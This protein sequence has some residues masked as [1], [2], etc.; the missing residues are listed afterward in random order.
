MWF[1]NLQIYRFTKPF[2]L[3]DSALEEKLAAHTFTPCNNQQTQSLGWVSPLGKNS[4]QLVHAANGYM[5]VCVREQEKLLPAS[6]INEQLEE[7]VRDIEAKEGREVYRK[8]KV[9]LKEALIFDLLPRAFSRSRLHFAYI[10]P[11]H[12]YLV[13]N[14]AS[15]SKAENLLN[16]LRES[17]GSLAVIP[18]TCKSLVAQ[19]MT[20]WLNSGEIPAPFTLGNDCVLKDLQEGASIRCKQYDLQADEIIAHITS[21]M[22]VNQLQVNWKDR[23]SCVIDDKLAIKQLK[24]TDLV[25]EDSDAQYSDD[26]AGQFDADFAIMTAELHAFIGDLITAFGGQAD[27]E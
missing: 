21:G 24:F 1:N 2:T 17:I 23:I 25:Q 14:S 15:A 18:L 4:Q 7:K 20:H 9:D 10:A 8:E 26:P 3:N 11:Q 22:V 16:L 13:V 12:G 5:M 27:E 6:V 19:S